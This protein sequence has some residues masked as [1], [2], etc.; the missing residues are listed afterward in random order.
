MS[1]TFYL[2]GI[3]ELRDLQCLGVPSVLPPHAPLACAAADRTL[4]WPRCPEGKSQI[5]FVYKLVLSM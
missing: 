5:A 4:C 1:R 2:A 3:R